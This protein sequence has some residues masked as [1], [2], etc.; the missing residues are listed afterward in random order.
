MTVASPSRSTED[1]TPSF[2]RSRR[3]PSAAF[4]S[5]PTMKRC[6]MCLTPG[7]GG[8][9][10]AR[11]R[12]A[13]VLPILIATPIGGGGVS[14]SPRKPVR[15]RARSSSVRQAGTTST[16]RN[17]AALSSASEE[18]RSIALSSIAFSG[19]RVRRQRRG[20]P[21]AHLEQLAL[22]R[23]VVDHGA[24]LTP[25]PWRRMDR[26]LGLLS[27]VAPMYDEEETVDALPRARRGRA[28]RASTSSWSSSTT[29]P[30]D[31]TAR[32]M[33]ASSPRADPRVKVVALS[34]NFGH[35]A[36]LTAGLEHAA[37]RRGGDARRRPAGPARGDPRDARA[38]ARGRRRRLRRAPA[39]GR[40][41]RAFK[42]H[43]RA[44]VLPRSSAASPSIDLARRV[45]RLPADGPRARSTR[46]W[47][48]PS[49][50]ASCAG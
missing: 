26:E 50:T 11:A 34:R 23:G 9:R 25:V 10:R 37:R 12:P 2:H 7:G 40:G 15:W 33:V 35:Q 44:L 38:L 21:A 8:H 17:S 41:R 18:A 1:A 20:Q 36:A 13:F 30:S 45:R 42:L 49:A 4:G 14:T 29:A 27:V 6:A 3:T 46:C 31:G 22:Q 39:S 48:C 32:R 19:L 24:E 16:K 43:H 5:S 47:R 28:G